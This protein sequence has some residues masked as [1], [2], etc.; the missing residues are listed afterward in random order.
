MTFSGPGLRKFLQ[1]G[2][3]VGCV[4]FLISSSKQIL[5]ALWP[6]S[7]LTGSFINSMLEKNAVNKESVNGMSNKYPTLT[8][9]YKS[10]SSDIV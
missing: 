5:Q 4:D 3:F 6:Q 8:E 1:L 2:H 9:G 7:M 10:V